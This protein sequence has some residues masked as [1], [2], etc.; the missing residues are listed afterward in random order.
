MKILHLSDTHYAQVIDDPE[1]KVV[2]ESQVSLVDKL[3]QILQHED[4]STFDF[5]MVTGDL[6]HEGTAEDYQQLDQL[7][8]SVFAPLPIYYCLGNHDRKPVFYEGMQGEK[9][10]D[11]FDYA[12]EWEDVQMIVLDSAKNHSHSGILD[13]SQI[14]WLK[15]TLKVS[16][17]PKM[18]FLHHPIIGGPYF[19][20]FTFEDPQPV[21]DLINSNQIIGVFTGHTH[22]PAINFASNTKQYTNYAM[23]FGLEK[24]RDGSQIFTNTCGYSVIEYRNY[25]ELTVAPRIIQPA[26][27]CYKSTSSEEMDSLNKSYEL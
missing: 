11:N 26:Y 14:D 16:S 17:F 8:K 13:P 7:L 20:K 19:N 27:T 5:V 9:R 23:S 21:L 1:L 4:L 15:Q 10:L 25:S 18:I 24:Q 3:Q 12:F 22:S 6:V 2:L